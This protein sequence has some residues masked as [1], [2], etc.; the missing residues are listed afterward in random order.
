MITLLIVATLA[1]EPQAGGT[2]GKDQTVVKQGETVEKK[3]WADGTGT[4]QD[5]VDLGS[6]AVLLDWPEVRK[7][8]GLTP[9][10]FAEIKEGLYAD[11]KIHGEELNRRIREEHFDLFADPHAVI[12][13]QHQVDFRAMRRVMKPDQVRRLTEIYLQIKG[14]FALVD[15]EFRD[16]FHL[17][18]DQTENIL[19]AHKKYTNINALHLRDQ[20]AFRNT[21]RDATRREKS[22]RPTADEERDFRI[23]NANRLEENF[24]RQQE[25]RD[26]AGR[27][28][29]RFLTKRQRQDFEKAKGE[30]FDLAGMME[31]GSLPRAER[32]NAVDLKA[33]PTAAG[34]AAVTPPGD[35]KARP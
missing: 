34:K 2:A 27:E 1:L 14:V 25:L 15:P 24:R 4:V 13:A 8:I 33:G 26:S 31:P 16:A 30:P 19:A 7:E 22:R 35:P 18:P 32:E 21:L 20:I 29:S 11:R 3:R 9:K 17:R 10:Q 12:G 28:I 6:P 23:A 5:S